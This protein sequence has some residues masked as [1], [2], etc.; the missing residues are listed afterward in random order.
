MSDSIAA[1][2]P[3]TPPSGPT[4][5]FLGFLYVGMLGFGGVLPWARR[6]IV[7][8]RRWLTA[9]EFTDQL[10]FCQFLP[11]PNICN[12]T[13]ALGQRFHGLAGALAAMTGL[14]AAP[15]AIAIALGALY[16]RYGGLPVVAHAFAGLAAAGSGLILA[17]AVKVGMPL[18]GKALGLGL[19]GVTLVGIAVLKLPLA[20]TMLTLA[21][22]SIWLHR[23][24]A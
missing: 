9:E 22:I 7:E 15:V 14:M 16:G 23:A 11:G 10:A 8:Q 5:L 24:R 2:A 21:P 17:T 13:I 12:M 19:A 3:P 4:A 1:G 20:P 18:R 6:M